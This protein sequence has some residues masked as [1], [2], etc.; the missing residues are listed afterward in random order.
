LTY[1]KAIRGL[2]I[3]LFLAAAGFG[4]VPDM[5]VGMVKMTAAHCAR[6]LVF[7]D[8]FQVSPTAINCSSR[9]RPLVP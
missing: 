7:G 1:V 2:A 5:Q 9:S 4:S 3:R 8:G 6:K